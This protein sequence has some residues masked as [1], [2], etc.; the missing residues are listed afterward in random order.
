MPKIDPKKFTIP[1]I[2]MSI[3]S[4][5]LALIVFPKPQMAAPKMTLTKNTPILVSGVSIKL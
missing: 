1:T 2:Q 5:F 4:H 3:F